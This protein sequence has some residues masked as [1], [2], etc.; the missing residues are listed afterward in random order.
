LEIAKTVSYRARWTREAQQPCG[1]G[2]RPP[3]AIGALKANHF[4]KSVQPEAFFSHRIDHGFE[5]LD[6]QV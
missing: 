6:R 3:A 2:S 4:E 1:L 5:L